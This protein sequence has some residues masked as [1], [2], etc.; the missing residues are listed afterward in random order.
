MEISASVHPPERREVTIGALL[1]VCSL[2]HDACC[3]ELPHCFIFFYQGIK[4]SIGSLVECSEGCEA[5]SL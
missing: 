3:A 4:S 1:T 2:V 5:M